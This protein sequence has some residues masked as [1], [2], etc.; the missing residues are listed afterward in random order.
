[1]I[2]H[3]N[4]TARA[5]EIL[6]DHDIYLG[7]CTGSILKYK[8]STKD[9]CTGVRN[10]AVS[11]SEISSLSWGRNDNELL[12]GYKNGCVA[13]YDTLLEEYNQLAKWDSSFAVKLLSYGS[14]VIVAE[15]RGKLS[16]YVSDTKKVTTIID[17]KSTDT[18]V[19]YEDACFVPQ[20]YNLLAVGG[21][22]ND[23]KIYD[24]NTKKIYFQAK[25]ER[26]DE[27]NLR[28]P[29][30]ISAMEFMDPNVVCTVTKEG[31]IRIHDPRVQRRAIMQFKNEKD[32]PCYT[33]I[34]NCDNPFRLL[35]GTNRGAVQAIDVRN[36]KINPTK[37]IKLSM[38]GISRIVATIDSFAFVYSMD[39]FLWIVHTD[40]LEPCY[41]DYIKIQA[42][43]LLAKPTTSMLIEDED[44]GHDEEKEEEGDNEEGDEDSYIPIKRN[45]LS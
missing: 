3:E 28:R 10:S 30:S 45:K 39:R 41:K 7:T 20:K 8:K 29:V 17:E 37:A 4:N 19:T 24:V 40:N 14:D 5:Q 42:T 9:K 36:N 21:V 22:S 33:C 23:L 27:L 15:K 11:K 12:I 25:N 18:T 1:M 16:C 43:S 35:I 38:G 2:G 13:V 32:L 34:S 26:H 44:E 31:N 6:R